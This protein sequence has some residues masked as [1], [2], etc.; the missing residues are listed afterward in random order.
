MEINYIQFS[1]LAMEIKKN[2]TFIRILHNDQRNTN[3]SDQRK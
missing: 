2:K 1:S 3:Q